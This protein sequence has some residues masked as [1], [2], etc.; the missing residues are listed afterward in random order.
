MSAFRTEP[1]DYCHMELWPYLAKQTCSIYKTIIIGHLVEIHNQK[2]SGW[3]D[4]IINRGSCLQAV[5]YQKR[6]SLMHKTSRVADIKPFHGYNHQ[7]AVV[8]SNN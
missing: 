1:H 8:W 3:D 5:Y 4:N 6:S 7:M 2:P